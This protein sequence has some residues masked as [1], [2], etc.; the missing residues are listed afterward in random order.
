MSGA[1]PLKNVRIEFDRN[2]LNVLPFSHKG[3][4]CEDNGV[5]ISVIY[6]RLG[7]P[8][9]GKFHRRPTYHDLTEKGRRTL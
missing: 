2:V 4:V 6:A 5:E 7:L 1:I 3:L 9:P 8:T